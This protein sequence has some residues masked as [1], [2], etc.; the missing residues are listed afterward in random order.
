MVSSWV[1]MN[2]GGEFSG[3]EL[4]LLSFLLEFTCVPSYC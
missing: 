3:G 4:R 1:L 2:R